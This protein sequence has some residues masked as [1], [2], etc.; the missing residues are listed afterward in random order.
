MEAA[1]VS[2]KKPRLLDRVRSDLRV[3]H[4]STRTEKAY[5]DW[6]RRFILFHG[7]RHPN[8]MGEREISAFLTHLAVDRHVA[9]STQNQ[10]F[11]ALL[12]LYQQVL[13]LKLDFIDDVARVKRPAKI[14]VVFTREEARAVLDQLD[15][16]Y[17]LM[18]ELLY[19]SGLRLMECV[20]LRVK[21][22]DFGYG[23][24]TVRDGK[25]L[26]DRVTLLPERLRRPLQLHLE[27]V[28]ELH[29]RDVAKGGGRVYLP[30]ALRRKYPTAARS[31]AWQ[32]VF[33][34]AKV[35]TD[36]RSHE[37]RRHH[38][39][40]KN[41][42]NA[43][44]LAIQR[45]GVAKAASCHTFR[46]SF[47][48][49]LLE[50]GYDIRTVQELLGH[51][52]REIK[53]GENTATFTFCF[54]VKT[55]TFMLASRSTWRQDCERTR[56]GKFL[57]RG[58]GRLSKWFIGRA[59]WIRLTQLNGRNTSKARGASD[60]SRTDCETISPGKGRFYDDDLHPRLEQT[61]AGRPE[62]AGRGTAKPPKSSDFRVRR[63]FFV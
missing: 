58:R 61:G 52:P 55:T 38:I 60:T 18:S 15:G 10:A 28:K 25:G 8:E 39:G 16:E 35:S 12:F 1:A 59:V 21:D 33:P 24:I 40:E 6:I 4:Y 13:Q 20:R 2:E 7:K 36:P 32:Y 3:K 57:P 5:I 53:L 11:C 49:H 62:P 50:N 45:A 42:Q 56:R 43:V 29:L 22:I 30:F 26:R 34:A 31:W 9:A 19:G 14:P 47:A 44:K 17:Q 51:S 54:P 37:I 23:H 41:L 27:R 63:N 46:H 48:T